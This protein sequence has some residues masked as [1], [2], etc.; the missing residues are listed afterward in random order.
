MILE[1]HVRDHKRGLWAQPVSE[2]VYPPE[3]RFLKNGEIRDA[4]GAV[5]G[6]A[7]EMRG[8]ARARGS[9]HLLKAS[10]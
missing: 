7:G 3:W 8:G 4:A 1:V 6:D 10:R 2:W 9:G 5:R